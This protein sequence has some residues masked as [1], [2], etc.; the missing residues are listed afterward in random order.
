MEAAT[1]LVKLIS[2]I[3]DNSSDLSTAEAFNTLVL[4]TQ[5]LFEFLQRAVLLW[6]GCT[7][8]SEPYGF[9]TGLRAK[10][11]SRRCGRLDYRMQNG[12]PN[13]AFNLGGGKKPSGWELDHIYDEEP[14]WSVRDGLHFTQSAGLVA[15]PRHAHRRRHSDSMLSWLVRGFSF[16]KFGYDPLTVFSAE[17]HDQFGFVAGR[18]CE[19]FWPDRVEGDF[20]N[21]SV[22]VVI[23]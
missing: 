17:A 20:N 6:S 15:M 12:P 5:G 16:L 21:L 13:S 22:A 11:K 19:V 14:M 1:P 2:Q 9:P 23:R 18:R 8:Q 7:R 10:W 3:G 4:A